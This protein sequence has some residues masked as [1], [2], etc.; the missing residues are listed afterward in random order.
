[1]TISC[2]CEVI[3]FLRSLTTKFIMCRRHGSTEYDPEHYLETPNEAD[4]CQ[5]Y[6]AE[7]DSESVSGIPSYV[8]TMPNEMPNQPRRSRDTQLLLHK[9]TS[10]STP[11]QVLLIDM[12][13]AKAVQH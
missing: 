6:K 13:S 8:I 5:S 3:P 7:Y 11:N 10:K 4:A 2:L 1:M 12:A 9:S